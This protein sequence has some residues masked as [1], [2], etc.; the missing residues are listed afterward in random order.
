MSLKIEPLGTA[1]LE[2]VVDGRLEEDDYEK[3]RPIAEAIIETNGRIGMLRERVAVRE[4][5]QAHVESA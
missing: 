5:V 4:W 1:G 2:L 3:L